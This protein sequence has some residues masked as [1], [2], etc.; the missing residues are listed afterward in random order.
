MLPMA[1]VVSSVILVAADTV[2]RNAFSPIEIPVGVVVA[3]IGVPYFI[4]LMIKEK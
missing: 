2:A 4:Y 3:V 1:A